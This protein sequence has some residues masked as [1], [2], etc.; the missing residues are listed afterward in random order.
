MDATQHSRWIWIPP[1]VAALLLAAI[2]LLDDNLALFIILNRTGQSLGQ[3]F[4]DNM[5]ILGDGAVTMTLVLPS[6]RRSPRRFWAALFGAA[7]VAIAVQVCKHLIPLP[8]PLSVLPAGAFFH[9]GPRLGA[10]AFPSGHAA[11]IFTLAGV[12]IISPARRALWRALLLALAV[13]VGVARIMVGVHWP[14]DVLAGMLLGWAAA[15]IGLWLAIRL[16]WKTA[17]TGGYVTGSFLLLLA[18][19]LLFSWHTGFPAAFLLQQ[20]VGLSCLIAGACEIYLMLE[21]RSSSL[22]AESH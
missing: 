5:S 14:T 9:S 10:V 8:R 2:Y 4:W 15:Y 13:V 18:V 3:T 22:A 21:N 7:V 19:A 12:W 1:V 20:L 16:D 17:C 11:A 6:I